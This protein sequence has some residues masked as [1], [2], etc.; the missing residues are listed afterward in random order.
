MTKRIAA[1]A[2]V[3]ALT[4]T[5]CTGGAEDTGEERSA[6]AMGE[7]AAPLTA[8][9]PAESEADG[10]TAEQSFLEYVRASLAENTSIPDATD[11]QL[12]AAGMEACDRM[13]AG[14]LSDT[15]SV[16]E[17]EAANG[18]GYFEDSGWIVSG[19]G[20]FLCPAS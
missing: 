18:L 2:A 14:E 17:G 15:I 6:P 9:K 10:E 13:A 11:D 4:L 5:G 19:A 16:V 3:L 8:D 1:L 20:Q 7:S 12:L